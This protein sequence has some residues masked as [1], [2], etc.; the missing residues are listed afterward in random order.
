MV[1]YQQEKKVV[2]W[3]IEGFIMQPFGSQIIGK[4]TVWQASK[5]C[6]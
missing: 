1:I 4:I 5:V 2:F 6:I 3:K